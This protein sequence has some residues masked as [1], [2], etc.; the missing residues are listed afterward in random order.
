MD[1]V[2]WL[3]TGALCLRQSLAGGGEGRGGA[4]NVLLCTTDH[5]YAN[6]GRHGVGVQHIAEAEAEEEDTVPESNGSRTPI[7]GLFGRRPGG[8]V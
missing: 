3:T 6:S 2:T 7:P 8:S 1:E 5:G 4:D